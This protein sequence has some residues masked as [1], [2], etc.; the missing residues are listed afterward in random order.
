MRRSE[1]TDWRQRYG[2]AVGQGRPLGRFVHA[3][4]GTH[5]QEGRRAAAGDHNDGTCGAIADAFKNGFGWVT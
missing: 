2:Q 1:A 5:Y 4:L 3:V